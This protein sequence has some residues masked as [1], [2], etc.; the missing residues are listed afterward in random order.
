MTAQ[1][2]TASEHPVSD[3]AKQVVSDSASVI[4]TAKDAAKERMKSRPSRLR[5][6]EPP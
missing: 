2:L 6:P 3:A 5:S 4:H 1:Q